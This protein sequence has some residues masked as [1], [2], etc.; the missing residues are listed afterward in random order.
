MVLLPKN[1]SGGALRQAR[2]RT[3]GEIHLFP[4]RTRGGLQG[5][6]GNLVSEEVC[7]I[8]SCGQGRYHL[9]LLCVRCL[10]NAFD[11]LFIARS[12]TIDDQHQTAGISIGNS[13][14]NAPTAMHVPS[15]VGLWRS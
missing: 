7:F 2:A 5:F 8:R 3:K 6:V 12:E 15:D 4:R 10:R 11:F 9:L 13:F 14:Q 1:R